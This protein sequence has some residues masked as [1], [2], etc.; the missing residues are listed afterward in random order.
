MKSFD[1]VQ[2]YKSYYSAGIEPDLVTIPE[3]VYVS[4][5]GAGSPGTTIFYKKKKAIKAFV[6]EL[7]GKLEATDKS[8]TGLV[9]EIFYWYDEQHAGFVD[10]G[11]FYTTVDLELLQ[12][13]IAVRIPDF[14]REEYITGTAKHS[15]NEFARSFE[16][17]TYTAGKCVQLLHRGPF[18]GELETLP[19]LQHYATSNG[20][21]KAGMHQEIHLTNFEPG[22]VQDHLQ[23]I[24]RDPVTEETK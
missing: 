9:V 1:V 17:F 12:Y 5:L 13:R 20:L 22:E 3:A 8:F 23:T 15:A 7:Q 6:E 18:A 16:Y 4:I 19:I 2:E 11:D 24:L 21:R 14:I 10:I